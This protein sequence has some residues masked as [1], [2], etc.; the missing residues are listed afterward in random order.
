MSFKIILFN[1]LPAIGIDI[2]ESASAINNHRCDS[3]LI[4]KFLHMKRC[5]MAM[6]EYKFN[7]N[8]KLDYRR[9]INHSTSIILICSMKS[10]CDHPLRKITSYAS[11]A[12][13]IHPHDDA[14][15]VG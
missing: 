14:A 3:R 5:T 2:D 7:L 15:C 11:H 4:V 10:S 13:P 9:K 8:Y 6:S 12:I 1:R